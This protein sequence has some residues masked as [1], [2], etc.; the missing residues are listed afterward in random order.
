MARWRHAGRMFLASCALGLAISSASLEIRASYPIVRDVFVNG[1]GPYRMLLDTGAQSTSVRPEVARN[2]GLRSTFAVEMHNT[3]GTSVVEGGKADRISSGELAIEGVEVLIAEPPAIPGSG[4]LDGVIG[5]SFLVR[6]NYWLDY[7][8]GKLLWDPNGVLAG[9]LEGEPLEFTL[10]DG[11]PAVRIQVTVQ[12]REERRLVL[13]SGASHL[14]LFGWRG[15]LNS[16]ATASV[17]TAQTQGTA[18][19]VRVGS[20]AAGRLSWRGLSAGIVETPSPGSGGLLPAHLLKSFYVNNRER[21]VLAGPR[22]SARCAS[23][24][25]E[26]LARRAEA[27]ERA[28]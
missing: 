18:R 6:T 25:A 4:S 17:R 13:D 8:R 24:L 10:V 26:P 3:L 2:I 16:T 21:Y 20:L 15:T 27:V 19:L 7:E 5:Q 9:C 23:V 28:C 11:R 22:L 12:D 1:K 14:I